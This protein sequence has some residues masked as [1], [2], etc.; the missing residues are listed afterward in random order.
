MEQ[1]FIADS[2]KPSGYST[3]LKR[4][5][6]GVPKSKSKKVLSK[7]EKKI[8]AKEVYHRQ[9][10]YLKAAENSFPQTS[11]SST[12]TPGEVFQF[13]NASNIYSGNGFLQNTWPNLNNS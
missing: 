13:N 12:F 9:V 8:A 10:A 11:I 3:D 6:V 5:R 7:M 1:N 4:A 2:S